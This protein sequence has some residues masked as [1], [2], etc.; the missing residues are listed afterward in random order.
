M[1]TVIHTYADPALSGKSQVEGGEIG[2][3]LYLIRLDRK[4]STGSA[5]P[6]SAQ[7]HPGVS[8]PWHRPTAVS[9]CAMA[10]PWHTALRSALQQRT[11]KPIAANPLLI[12]DKM[13]AYQKAA[14]EFA[15]ARGGRVLLGHEM[16]LGKTPMDIII[17]KNSRS[18]STRLLVVGKATP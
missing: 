1:V 11:A 10:T 13:H 5:D 16:G 17:A 6:P 18:N 14:V 4:F 9:A 3:Y 12:D 15:L 8:A 2:T 7:P